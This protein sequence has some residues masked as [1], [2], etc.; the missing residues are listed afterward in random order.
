VSAAATNFGQQGT[1]GVF[2]APPVGHSS[3]SGICNGYCVPGYLHAAAIEPDDDPV[4]LRSN[5]PPCPLWNIDLGRRSL[6]NHPPNLPADSIQSLRRPY[7]MRVV[8]MGRIAQGHTWCLKLAQD[9][10]PVRQAIRLESN[11]PRYL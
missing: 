11:V 2:S 6:H 10:L 5:G 8:C 9:P 3:Y 4:F 1:A 7:F